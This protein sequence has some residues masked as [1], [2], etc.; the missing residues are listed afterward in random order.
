MSE[1]ESGTGKGVYLARHGQTAYNLEGRFQG[2]LP[3]PLDEQGRE[4]AHELAESAAAHGFAVLWSSTL[5][6]ARETAEIVAARIGLEPKEDTRLVE[7][8]AGD[9]TD[10]PFADVQAQAPELF[11][12][13]IAGD[14]TFAFPGGESFARQEVRVGAALDEIEQGPLPALVVCHGM[15]I[16]AALSVRAGHWLPYGQR[17]PNGALVPLDPEE[18]AR[19][20]LGGEETT[21]AS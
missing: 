2:Q 11:A 8:D 9:W 14:P 15:V 10:R 17:V 18:L 12:K 20:D 7:T 13:F 19:T 4:Q 6:R 3:V 5:L 21:Q 1:R 16:R